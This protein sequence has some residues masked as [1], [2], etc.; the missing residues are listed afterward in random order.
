ML[1]ARYLADDNTQLE[2][3]IY[4]DI[5]SILPLCRGKLGLIQ[6]DILAVLVFVEFLYPIKYTI[7]ILLIGLV[8]LG[9]I[10][11]FQYDYLYSG[12][13]MRNLRLVII[14]LIV[15]TISYIDKTVL[16]PRKGISIKGV[17]IVLL[18]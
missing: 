13:S 14:T 15:I 18:A 1:L 6:L 12:E 11:S 17:N 9:K 2:A 3:K 4:R 10:K 7:F 16:N 8:H 5:A